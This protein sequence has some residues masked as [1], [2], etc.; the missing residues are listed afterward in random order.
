MTPVSNP[1]PVGSFLGH[2]DGRLR[3]VIGMDCDSQLRGCYCKAAHAAPQI[4]NGLG[5]GGA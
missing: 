3:D 5:P 1:D 2:G 4:Q